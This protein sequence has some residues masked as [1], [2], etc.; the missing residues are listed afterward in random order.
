MLYLCSFDRALNSWFIPESKL[1]LRLLWAK[2][3]LLK[4]RQIQK[5]RMNQKM[6]ENNPLDMTPAQETATT[7]TNPEGF[8]WHREFVRTDPSKRTGWS[9]WWCTSSSWTL[10][11]S[12]CSGPWLPRPGSSWIGRSEL[13][14]LRFVSLR[15]R[16][17]KECFNTQNCSSLLG[18]FCTKPEK[19]ERIDL[20]DK[21]RI[22]HSLQ[23]VYCIVRKEMKRSRICEKW[24]LFG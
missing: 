14:S 1:D 8:D 10:Q 21:F 24:F 6:S 5:W 19:T 11:R 18:P 2:G 7:C 17:S 3:T 9:D 13:S 22:I 15:R 12:S 23:K 20:W 4:D 16:K